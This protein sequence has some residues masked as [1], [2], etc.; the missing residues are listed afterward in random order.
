MKKKSKAGKILKYAAFVI[1]VIVIIIVLA[2]V[3][4]IT[5]QESK[6]YAGRDINATFSI[7]NK[8][9]LSADGDRLNF[10]MVYPGGDS[11]KEIVLTNEYKEPLKV[12][13]EYFGSITQV[14]KPVAPFYIDPNTEKKI[15]L[16]A[17]AISNKYSTYN[18]T[19]RILYIKQ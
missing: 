7:G 10:G 18:G 16:T 3:G 4:Y 17:Y 1:A 12:E 19:V 9:G 8:V 13:I 14:L 15:D 2:R 11:T 5:Y 6:I